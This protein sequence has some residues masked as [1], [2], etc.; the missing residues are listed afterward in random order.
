MTHH[1]F[2][3]CS[4]PFFTTT[5]DEVSRTSKYSQFIK[6]FV[7]SH[8]KKTAE[9]LCSCLLLYFVIYEAILQKKVDFWQAAADEVKRREEAETQQ[10]VAQLNAEQ[11]AAATA[12][13]GTAETPAEESPASE[14]KAKTDKQGNPVDERGKL[15]TENVNSIDDLTDGDFTSA[16][17]SVELPKIPENVDR[18]IGA[19]GKPVIIKKSVLERNRTRHPDVT[20]EQSREILKA[21]LYTPDLYGQNQKNN[22]PHNWVLIRTNGTDGKNRLVLLEVN[23]GKDNVE[24]VHWHYVS[25]KNLELIKKRAAREDAQL[26]ILPSEFTEEVGGLSN[27][28]PGSLSADKGMTNTGN[29]QV[30]GEKKGG[31]AVKTGQEL[32]ARV[33]KKVS[34]RKLPESQAKRIDLKK[35]TANEANSALSNVYYKDGYIYATDGKVAIKMRADYP[36]EY[37]GKMI[38]PRTGKEVEG[39]HVNVDGAMDSVMNGSATKVE[40]ADVL[41]AVETAEELLKGSSKKGFPIDMVAVSL[42][43]ESGRRGYKSGYAHER[44]YVDAKLLVPIAELMRNSDNFEVYVTDRGMVYAADGVMG[45]TMFLNPESFSGAVIQDGKTYA[46]GMTLGEVD[47]RIADLRRELGGLTDARK[48]ANA[49]K[50]LERW[51]DLR[52]NARGMDELEE[53]NTRAAREEEARNEAKA[54]EWAERNT[55]RTFTDA[56]SG[57]TFTIR[58]AENGKVEWMTETTLPNG[59]RIGVAREEDA[60]FVA[61]RVSAGD[62]GEEAKK[63]LAEHLGGESGGWLDEQRKKKNDAELRRSAEKRQAAKDKAAETRAR[64]KQ[65]ALEEKKRKMEEQARKAGGA[66]QGDSGQNVSFSAELAEEEKRRRERTEGLAGSMEKSLARLGVPHVVCRTAEELAA[67]YRRLTGGEMSAEEARTRNAFVAKDRNGNDVVVFNAEALTEGRTAEEAALKGRVIT[68]H[69]VLGHYGLPLLMGK[70]GYDGFCSKVYG[71]MTE[72]ARE[73]FNAYFFDYNLNRAAQREILGKLGLGEGTRWKELTAEQKASVLGELGERL[74]N[75]AADEYIAHLAERVERGEVLPREER[76]LWQ[77][78]VDA[79]RRLLGFDA[80]DEAFGDRDIAKAIMDSKRNLE[81]RAR[82]RERAEA[83]E[84][85]AALEGEIA[86]ARSRHDVFA[87]ARAVAELDALRRGQEGDARNSAEDEKNKSSNLFRYFSGSLSELVEK[88]KERAHDLS[89]KVLSGVSQKFRDELKKKGI[90]IDEEYHHVI[91]NYA[92]HHI[93]NNH[94]GEEERLRGQMPVTYEDILKIPDII[95]NYNNPIE[96]EKDGNEPPRIIFS[97]TY[98]DGT[99]IYVEEQRTGRKELAAVSLRKMKRP[100]L[101]G[102][103][104]TNTPPIPDLGRLS[105]GKGSE[106]VGTGKGNGEN[107]SDARNGVDENFANLDDREGVR[108]SVVGKDE[109][110]SLVGVHNISEEKLRKALKLGGLANPSVA[111]IDAG[112]FNHDGFGGISLVTPPEMIDRRTG[113][114]AGTWLGDAWTPMFPETTKQLSEESHQRMEADVEKLPRHMHEGMRRSLDA[115]ADGN[116]NSVQVQN[117]LSYLYLSDKGIAIRV[118]TSREPYSIAAEARDYVAKNGMDGDFFNWLDSL[119]DRYGVKNVIFDGFSPSGNRKYIPVTLENVSRWMKKQGQ[120]GSMSGWG[121]GNITASV[122]PNVGTLEEIRTNKGRLSEDKLGTLEFDMMKWGPVLYEIERSLENKGRIADGE[123]TLEEAMGRPNPQAYLKSEYNIDLTEDESKKI[124]DFIK[125]V[126]EERP[127]RYFE[128]KFERPVYL[129]EFAGAVVPEG[130]GEDIMQ[131]LRD[132]G[133]RVETYEKGRLEDRRR[134]V[135]ELAEAQDVRF[136]MSEEERKEI[137]G[138]LKSKDYASVLTG[139]EF[140]NEGGSIG[141]RV[142]SFYKEKYGGRVFREGIGEVILDK[143]GVRSSIAHGLRGKKAVAFAAVPD[144]ITKGRVIDTQA[145]WKDRDYRSTTIAAPIK[146]GKGRYIGTVVLTRGENAENFR[147]YLHKVNSRKDLLDESS[148]TAFEADTHQGGIANLLRNIL[149]PKGNGE[150]NSPEG[151]KSS[152]ARF[153]AEEREAAAERAQS[154]SDEA[155]R[156]I[157]ER[158]RERT[159]ERAAGLAE[160][161][162]A[163]GSALRGE[164]EGAAVRAAARQG[165][166]REALG[167]GW[168]DFLRKVYRGAD[169]ESLHEIND[170]ARRNGWNFAAATERWLAG[171]ADDGAYG[172]AV[173]SGMWDGVK[174]AFDGMLRDRGVEGGVTDGDARYALWRSERNKTEG[175]DG[176]VLARA[177][178]RAAEYR[179]DRGDARFSR[180]DENPNDPR[181]LYRDGV[182]EPATVAREMERKLVVQAGLGLRD[183]F[184]NWRKRAKFQFK[185]SVQDSMQSLYEF[186]KL[187]LGKEWKGEAE[188]PDWMNPYTRENRLSS[189]NDDDVDTFTRKYTL[190]M[191]EEVKKLARNE[192]GRKTLNR[193]MMAKH[194]LERNEY[195]AERNAREA[196]E[197]QMSKAG[198]DAAWDDLP[199][200]AREALISQQRRDY[201]GLTGLF[202]LEG[203]DWQ[204]AEEE[205]RALVESYETAHDTEPLWESVRAVTDAVL[206]KQL[207]TGLISRATY[208]KVKGMYGNYIP[209]MGFDEA[210]VTDEYAYLN[211]QRSQFE[212]PL[213][214]AEGRMWRAGCGTA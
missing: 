101:T 24:V 57:D 136:S 144:I 28:T 38:D 8:T 131:A 130:T 198:R 40:T 52:K 148:T 170:L 204:Q 70:E 64:N 182:N 107:I 67:E 197:E 99:T 14:G 19:D 3:G 7:F 163:D 77:S 151:E 71:A 53:L 55:G 29:A 26:L 132:A 118:S 190:P 141:E 6:I 137:G 166:L 153:S 83:R 54:A 60:G 23:R 135:N 214:R 126:R 174:E 62:F 5:V 115:W 43:C 68:A 95:E 162:G 211:G 42:P 17:R 176:S 84:R 146:I 104:R 117:M 184:K 79:V 123:A 122:L 76:T 106:N 109:D 199:Y 34:G 171:L 202:G 37:E 4:L 200:E 74:T 13:A 169:A 98:E 193:Y 143:E 78:I 22:R 15:I 30:E 36:A 168:D 205:A 25:D 183:R 149:S 81:E 195:M 129:N 21:A 189:K 119:D 120:N 181:V 27:R 188:V 150:K 44:A 142:A 209:L 114:N 159:R 75:G 102:A 61:A 58:K 177:D 45:V 49:Q 116:G 178:D 167:K 158:E 139:D 18:A 72:E 165:T 50:E 180:E 206:D 47:K 172:R 194:G 16:T 85:A 100:S 155:E 51:E 208:D 161:L 89:K 108:F 92:I 66:A 160:G 94:G 175:A 20:P 154:I 96:V 210:T 110:K 112:K 63:S 212:S 87:E 59:K 186:M 73:S 2:R 91:D 179:A 191:Y 157:E 69:E 32:K 201:A 185:E 207:S 152:D 203:K 86:D 187:T 90:E 140:P 56:R 10:T 35:F 48:R 196:F 46:D 105:E 156:R 41:S 127:A 113:R 82:E 133:L 147:F 121:A 192:A 88:A 125:A 80:D 97:K 65:K 1:V 145:N 134:A 111:V 39:K 12:Q 93:M 138:Y 33:D 31:S 124:D 164:T 11:G 103:K 128:T 213:R 9:V 173:E